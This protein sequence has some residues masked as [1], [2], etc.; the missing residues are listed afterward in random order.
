MT[1]YA[2]R[3]LDLK[4]RFFA[5][6]NLDAALNPKLCAQLTRSLVELSKKHDKQVIITTHNPAVLDG[7][8][9]HDDAQR[10]IVVSRKANGPTKVHRVSPPKPVESDA[11]FPAATG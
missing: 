6:D 3:D 7:L 10:L 11:Q 9:L 1:P 2:T 4:R 8:D 5:I